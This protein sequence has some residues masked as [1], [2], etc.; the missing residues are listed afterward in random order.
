MANKPGLGSAPAS[1]WG[2]A[3]LRTV[4]I[5]ALASAAEDKRTRYFAARYSE[6]DPKQFIQ[7]GA[8]KQ[9]G[10]LATPQSRECYAAGDARGFS[11]L[12]N[13]CDENDGL[14]V[15]RLTA[16]MGCLGRYL[17]AI[18]FLDRAGRLTLY[19][20]LTSRLATSP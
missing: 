5:P 11:F 17:E 7:T 4:P 2:P 9:V 15:G 3:R 18:A 12:H 6:S 14:D 16:C 10:A 19:G 13:V 8:H 20:A 1:R